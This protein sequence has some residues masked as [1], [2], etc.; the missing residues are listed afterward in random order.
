MHA[1]TRGQLLFLLLTVLL[2][3][4]AACAPTGEAPVEGTEILWDEYGVPHVFSEDGEGLF[5]A[6]GWAQM[7]SHGSLVLR[8]YGHA[9][10]R[11]AEYWSDEHLA[12]DRWV[13]TVRIPERAEEWYGA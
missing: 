2:L 5:R 1:R 4:P 7:R 12:S 11:A 10:G 6:F 8:L 13:H 9:R 3:F